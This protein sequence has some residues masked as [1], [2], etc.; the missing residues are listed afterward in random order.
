MADEHM[1][2][3]RSIYT[4]LTYFR[5]PRLLVIFL[6]GISSG[7]P[8]VMIGSSLAAWL[9]DEGISRTTVGFIGAVFAVYSINFLWSPLVDRIRIFGL[10]QL[11]GLRR[12]WILLAQV[13]I[14]L[15]CLGLSSLSSINDIWWVGLFALFI[16]I[17]S[18]TQDIAIDAYRVDSIDNK[19]QSK[20]AAAAAMATSGWWTGYA[21]LGAIAF[22]LADSHFTW[23]Q[24]YLMLACIMAA[25]MLVVCLI[26]EPK[27]DRLST[28]TQLERQFQQRF[29][30]NINKSSSVLGKKVMAIQI[31]LAVSFIGPI[32]EFFNRSGTRLALL[33][34]LFIM[35]FKLGEAF[36]GRMSIV[37]YKEIGFSNSDIGFYSKIISWWVTVI[38]SLIGGIFTMRFGIVKGLFAAGIAM[39][40]SNLMLAWLAVVGPNKNILLAAVLIDGFTMAWSS[41]AMVAFISML[42]ERT[43]SASQ[44]ALLASLSSLGRTVI[45]SSSGALVEWLNG[46]WAL[47]FVITTL[48]VIPALILLNHI[49]SDLLTIE[50]RSK[51]NVDQQ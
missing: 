51:P 50:K 6:L 9:T 37:F 40:L 32:R 1:T 16:S 17:S 33:L 31:W 39:S 4:H 21:G 24:I 28:I 26:K 12:S 10:Y 29:A 48:M 2:I 14:I 5:E 25:F 43:F 13:G 22:F 23:P 8:G 47:F 45:G 11:F 49:K 38:F 19:D 7:F 30:S 15:G 20:T 44:Y 35:L 36:L 42:C 41:V 27:I 3:F 34:L 46:N 18:A